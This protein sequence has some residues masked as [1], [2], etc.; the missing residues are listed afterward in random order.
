M[1]R[2]LAAQGH[3]VTMVA[4]RVMS[5]QRIAM[6]WAEPDLGEIRGIVEP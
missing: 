5:S 6:G 2:R 1:V 3:D 4:E